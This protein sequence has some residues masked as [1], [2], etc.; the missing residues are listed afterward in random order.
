MKLIKQKYYKKISSFFIY[1]FLLG[2]FSSV[3]ANGYI[4]LEPPIRFET[5]TELLTEINNLL[6]Y[7][8]IALVG[9][10]VVMGA[11]LITFGGHNQEYLKKGKRI[12]V[13][14]SVGLFVL[15]FS[16]AILAAIRYVVGI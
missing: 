11:F 15:L 6:I 10:M 16:R 1:L 14:T 7:T 9:L 8:G 5:I 2:G 12:L 4:E 3:Y 13:W